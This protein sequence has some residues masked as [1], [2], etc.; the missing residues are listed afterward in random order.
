M[1]TK[2]GPQDTFFLIKFKKKLSDT[3]KR[4][5]SPCKFIRYLMFEK[6]ELLNC[7]SKDTFN[8]SRMN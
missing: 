8:L 7:E 5:T 2:I 1:S 4:E 3:M 6:S